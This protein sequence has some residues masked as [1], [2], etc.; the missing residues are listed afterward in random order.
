MHSFVAGQDLGLEGESLIV[1]ATRVW[2]TVRSKLLHRPTHREM[3]SF[4][5]DITEPERCLCGPGVR[6]ANGMQA[7]QG[8]F[9]EPYYEM[10]SGL[11]PA[12]LHLRPVRQEK[13]S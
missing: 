1:E 7:L 6:L 10:L 4:N 11:G 3:P 9:S 2:R 13:D 12:S 8:E 5:I